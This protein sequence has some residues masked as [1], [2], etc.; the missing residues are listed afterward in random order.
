MNIK[1]FIIF[2][3]NLLFFNFYF[4]PV[5]A[6]EHTQKAGLFSMDVPKEWHWFE[7]PQEI[8]ITYPDGKTMAFDIQM[9]PSRKLSQAEIKKNL[10]EG[11]DK[12]IKEG[13]EAHNGNLIDDKE[14]K[15]DG[16]YATRLDF[17]TASPNTV[18]GTYISFFNKGYAFTVTYGSVNDKTHLGMDDAIATFKF[19]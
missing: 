2:A 15:I 16:V 10:K 4:K 8:I 5:L 11:K 3:V 1:I 19:K 9:I 7:Y 6:L 13:I 18:Y 17:K 14:I 12:M